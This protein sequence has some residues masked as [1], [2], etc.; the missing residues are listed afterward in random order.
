MFVCSECGEWIL[1]GQA[2]RKNVKMA[3]RT[4]ISYDV[5]CPYCKEHIGRMLWGKYVPL[6]DIP[7]PGGAIKVTREGR[8][9]AERRGA[10]RR[11]VERRQEERRQGD[12]G[13]VFLSEVPLLRY[14]G[15]ERRRGERR[16]ADRRAGDRRRTDR[17]GTG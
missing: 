9:G 14:M 15:A 16:K 12:A 8:R 2:V 11:R 4:E 17:R 5:I 7:P 3:A 1:T 13:G 6:K 10:E